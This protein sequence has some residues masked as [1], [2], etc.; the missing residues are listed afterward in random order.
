MV[1]TLELAISKASELPEAAQEQLGR[2]LLERIDTLAKLRAEI[3]IGLQQLDEG[4]GEELD[5]EALLRQ[6]RRDHGSE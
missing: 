1:K 3:E 2:E 6:A 5:L 4:R